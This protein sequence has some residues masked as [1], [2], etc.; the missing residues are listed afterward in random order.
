M[1]TEEK[2]QVSK[3]EMAT[4]ESVAKQVL[5]LEGNQF[6]SPASKVITTTVKGV[7]DYAK[8]NAQRINPD[9]SSTGHVVISYNNNSVTLHH[10][11]WSRPFDDYRDIVTPI[12]IVGSMLKDP[13]LNTILELNKVSH[14]P[15]NLSKWITR[16]RHLFAD[17]NRWD[18]LRKGL[19]E[20][21]AKVL[22][23]QE[24]NHDQERGSLKKRFER[25]LSDVPSWSI[26]IKVPLVYGMPSVEL[27]F[28]VHFDT[29][30]G[31]V[32]ASLRN[33]SLDHEIR[34]AEEAA[35]QNAL[36]QLGSILP[37]VPQMMRN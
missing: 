7:I 21:S 27:V 1:S 14:T 36:A 33:W 18:E 32:S 13:D 22:E 15:M 9:Q 3:N 6:S 5:R 17:E 16:N 2:N 10:G 35:M 20:F 28:S 8:K 19:M 25:V 24:N 37:D 4:T 29:I 26:G 31:A 34:L 11:L 23:V 30:E 12:D